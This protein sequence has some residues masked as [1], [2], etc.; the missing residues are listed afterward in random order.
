MK[1]NDAGVLEG[2]LACCIPFHGVC[3]SHSPAPSFGFCNAQPSDALTAHYLVPTDRM[4]A[5]DRRG[6]LAVGGRLTRL[7]KVLIT[8]PPQTNPIGPSDPQ[9]SRTLFVIR[10]CCRPGPTSHSL[11]AVERASA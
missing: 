4:A 9:T 11:A 8:A 10:T 6:R 7:A 5:Q 1:I 2:S 3:A